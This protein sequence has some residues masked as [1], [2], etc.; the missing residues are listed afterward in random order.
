M[1]KSLVYCAVLS[2]FAGFSA[3]AAYDPVNPAD[4]PEI[5]DPAAAHDADADPFLHLAHPAGAR[6]YHFPTLGMEAHGSCFGSGDPACRSSIEMPSGER[7][8][9]MW[10]S[11]GG[12]L[13][14]IPASMSF[15]QV[16]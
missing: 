10:P 11:R 8:K 3:N 4:Y 5:G 2:V 15:R 1:M 16:S 6:A 9:A 7:T 13:M 14:G 12:R